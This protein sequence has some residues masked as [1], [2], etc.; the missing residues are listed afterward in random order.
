MFLC[1]IELVSLLSQ[2]QTSTPWLI[3]VYNFDPG[4]YKND[5]V[6]LVW[7][8]DKNRQ[9]KVKVTSREKEIYPKGSHLEHPNEYVLLLRIIVEAEDRD[10]LVEIADYMKQKF[11]ETY[12]YINPAVTV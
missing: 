5:E 12:D 10:Q 8:V 11:P 2:K 9:F 6:L 1:K 7:D 3:G 4:I